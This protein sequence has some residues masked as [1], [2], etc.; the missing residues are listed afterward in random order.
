MKE[1]TGN[2][3]GA[4][5]WRTAH[6]LERWCFAGLGGWLSRGVWMAT[7]MAYVQLIA[8]IRGL[9]GASKKAT[10]KVVAMKESSSPFTDGR[11][12]A[13]RDLEQHIYDL[14]NCP[15]DVPQDVLR[16]CYRWFIREY[17][18]YEEHFVPCPEIKQ[19]RRRFR[20]LPYTL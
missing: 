8:L 17:L 13:L 11:E 20:A 6:T 9:R 19:Y 5:W 4:S 1:C 15:A 18:L 3:R 7:L 10:E 16:D 14:E 2:A 12:A